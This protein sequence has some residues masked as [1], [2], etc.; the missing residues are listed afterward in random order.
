MVDAK[1]G[2]LNVKCGYN[3]IERDGRWK[4]WG[5]GM[6]LRCKEPNPLPSHPRLSHL[7]Q[8]YIRTARCSRLFTTLHRRTNDLRRR[9][10]YLRRR[11]C[12]VAVSDCVAVL[13][14]RR[15]L[16]TYAVLFGYHTPCSY[17]HGVELRDKN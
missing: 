5:W 3:V 2:K 8:K 13:L 10:Y 14:R 17:I 1:G 15:M 11:Y 16:K 7:L 12:W 4:T 6:E 9:R